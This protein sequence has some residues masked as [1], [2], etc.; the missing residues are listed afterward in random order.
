MSYCQL[1]RPTSPINIV[2][3]Q[4]FQPHPRE[5]LASPDLSMVAG[6]AF[7]KPWLLIVDVL[8]VS[9]GGIAWYH[10]QNKTCNPHSC[11]KLHCNEVRAAGVA[12]LSYKSERQTDLSAVGS[13]PK[14]QTWNDIKVLPR[15]LPWLGLSAPVH[16]TL[17]VDL[18]FLVALSE[19][20]PPVSLK[21]LLEIEIPSSI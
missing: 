10:L 16:E 17:V 4:P 18:A 9:L 13:E 11:F 14:L 7:L 21:C 1:R 12:L 6:R 15:R 19:S 3:V 2:L 5:E 20:S 8:Y